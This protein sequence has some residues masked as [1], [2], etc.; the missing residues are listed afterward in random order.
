MKRVVVFLM[1]VAATAVL[2]P[3]AQAVTF[4]PIRTIGGPGHAELYGWGMATQNDGTVLVGDYWNM[5]IARYSTTGT[6]L[7]DVVTDD[8][9]GLGAGQ[10]QSPYGIAVDPRNSD[11]YFGDV[12]GNKTV[13]K[14]TQGGQ[15]LFEFGGNGVGPGRYQYPSYLA[16]ANNGT[17]FVSDQWEHN[18]VA[19]NPQGQELFQFGSMGTGPGQFRQPR[20]MDIDGQGRLYVADNY[21]A[22]IQVFTATGAFVR[23]FG[24]RG[25]A[26]GQFGNNPDLRGV[27]IDDANGWVYVVNA[28]TG[29]VNKYDLNG[30]FLLRFGG[31]GTGPGR[32]PGGGR[33]VTVA[34]NGNVWVGDMPA[35]RAQVFSP[36]GQF[37]FQ[38]PGTDAGPPEGGFNQPRGVSVDTAGN[39]YVTD[40]H[41]W[42]IQKFA[43]NGTFLQEF[44]SR[45][46][47]DYSFNYQRGISVDRR[48]NSFVVADTDN[49]LIKK[50]SSTGAFLWS[51]GGFGGGL[52]QFRNPHSLDVG[53][54]GR[55]AVADTQNQRVVLL[56]SSGQPLSMFGSMGGGNGQFRFPRSVSWDTDGTLW[57]SDSIRGDVQHFTSTGQFLGRIAPSGSGSNSLL[58]AAD[59][60]VGGNL[61]YVAD[62]DAH[63]VKV[64]TKAGVFQGAFGG[65][66]NGNLLRPHGMELV[67][68]RLYV[69]EQTNE[70]VTEFRV[71]P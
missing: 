33:D 27:A 38:V 15:F 24:S 4:T 45:G 35:F 51:R 20:G 55:I 10:H 36:T 9:A 21:N 63:R 34:G 49:H 52:G 46:G 69:V 5:R 57:V 8:N 54:D 50:Y 53:A 66:G 62:V 32:F 14:Y 40:T 30:N 41:N 56:S 13:D 47:G 19:V 18:V 28:S 3:A 71:V 60:E 11:V 22:R 2:A 43:P 48:D 65:P 61:V 42:R 58:R 44:G 1:V 29:H 70:R 7:G 67:G 31:F 37:L 6:F 23:Q 68:D 39:I 16:V 26:P 64:W 12:D 17:V 59:V 25:S